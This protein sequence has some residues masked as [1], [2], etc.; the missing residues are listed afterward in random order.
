MKLRQHPPAREE[1]IDPPSASALHL[2]CSQCCLS[3]P[4]DEFRRRFAGREARVRQ[5]HQCH[6]EAERLRRL[7][8]QSRLHRQA[9]NRQLARLKQAKSARQVALVCDSM[10]RAFGGLEHFAAAWKDRLD[11]DLAKGGLAAMR[12]LEAV[13]RLVHHCE[14]NR[15]DCS[16]MSDE[17][18]NA[19]LREYGHNSH[20]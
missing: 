4:S 2:I 16:Q 10:I 8:K 15:P 7:A 14:E 19:I 11:A 3:K 17:E 5:C 1:C 9:V 6:A 13:L 20:G 18:L 12:H